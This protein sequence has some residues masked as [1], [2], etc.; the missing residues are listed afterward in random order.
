MPIISDPQAGVY[1]I[2]TPNSSLI[3]VVRDGY[4]FQ[5]WWGARC[6]ERPLASYANLLDLVPRSSFSPPA[7]GCE[8]SPDAAPLALPVA[9]SGDSRHPA[10]HIR[11]ADGTTSS[12]LEFSG[13]EITGGVF[14]FGDLPHIAALPE[15]T[16]TTLTL[17]LADRF[18]NISVD[19][20]YSVIEDHDAI[21]TSSAV[22]NNGTEPCSVRTLSSA[23]MHF[24][25]A[26][27]EMLTLSGSWAR[28]RA[29]DRQK[30][31]RG[32][33]SIGNSR[34]MSGHL[35]NPFMAI[36]EDGAGETSGA[37]YGFSL[38]WSG[39]F[40][41]TTERDQYDTLRVTA[42]SG[43]R[44]FAWKLESGKS[45]TSPQAVLVY[46][47]TGLG[48]M[49]R[50]YHRL[51]RKN[52]GTGI[53]KNRRRPV[54]VNNW[55]A[56]YFSFTREKLESIIEASAELG[57][58]LFVLDD[59]WFGKR[60]SDASSLGDWVPHA[61]KLPDGLSGI[62]GTA[63]KNG[64]GFGLW[65]EPEMIS[66]DSN[67]YR[68]HPDWCVHISG[69]AP[70]E[71]R[72]QLVLDMSR[73]E[74]R[75]YIIETLSAI[76]RSAK[77]EY[78]K[79]DF[80]RALTD[81][82]TPSLPADRQGEFSHRFVLGTWDVMSRL[83]S[84]FPDILFEGCAGGGGRFDPGILYY[85]SQI[86]TSDDTDAKERLAIQY[87]TSI[88]YPF[89]AIAAH[90]SAV[91]NHQCGRTTPLDFRAAVA[92]TGAFG[93]ELDITAMNGSE[94]ELIKKQIARW[95]LRE[96]IIRTG[97]VFRLR[98]PFDGDET[99]WVFVTEDKTEA[100]L[101]YFAER[102]VPNPPLKRLAIDGLDADLFYRI[103]DFD[104][105]E[106]SVPVSGFPAVGHVYQGRDLAG[107]GIPL[108][109]ARQDYS[110][111]VLHLE[112]FSHDHD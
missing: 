93:Y 92:M 84:R 98:S 30:I 57:I 35:F 61:G 36:L 65:F 101:C 96:A 107:A 52:L 14:P 19:L 29:V 18:R 13:G 4:L 50:T 21:F 11:Y 38:V 8:W 102:S 47:G 24:G 86:W 22:T 15:E 83:V 42:A 62:A 41:I 79:W 78:V 63:G 64:M 40:T 94:K 20:H 70:Q 5:P 9:G 80:N 89:S 75:E 33:H 46:S 85:M 69:L 110:F 90:V 74:V 108:P 58:E 72:N 2:D 49:S 54:L 81:M 55:E 28:E 10:I 97:D 88:V 53:R 45:F 109:V 59:G 68:S 51:Y 7:P 104:L 95:K 23:C 48:G 1:R 44:D 25:D 99:A 112:V 105:S 91:P 26:N 12:R 71:S 17:H 87:G 32:V 103:A 100:L 66:A 27:R 56:T 16:A 6:G 73:A 76:L 82:A 37:V 39:D 34:G 43:S 60:D 77:I 3:F 111:L 31:T 67:L 106:T